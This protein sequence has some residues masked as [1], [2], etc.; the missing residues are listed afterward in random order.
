[1]K[2]PLI[3][4]P[5]YVQSRDSFDVTVK[6][7][8]TVGLT[9]MDAKVCVCDDGSAEPYASRLLEIVKKFGFYWNF[10]EEN[11]GFSRTVNAGLRQAH[12]SGRDAILCN[13]DVEFTYPGWWEPFY[14]N[15]D[16]GERVPVAPVQGA[17]LEFPGRP[18]LVQHAGVYFSILRR[19]FD[20]IGRYAP[21]DMGD[22]EARRVC[23]VS[24]ALMFISWGNLERV[25][26]FDESFRMG[27]ED[28]D[29][30]IR[31]FEAG[32]VCLYNPEVQAI[33]HE[34]FFRSVPNQQRAIWTAE[35]WHRLWQ[36]HAGTDF[37]AYIPTMIGV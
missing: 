27:W 1:M 22:L 10:Q 15:S 6:C 14:T 18:R 28:V 32:E 9:A 12:G 23:P 5:T 11:Q 19:E 24:A 4:I 20:H 8:Q 7:L 31:T 16:D 25:G 30:C 29:Y 37:S 26:L 21:V 3:V 2:A 35:S 33:H 36:K 34:S 17:R 13:A